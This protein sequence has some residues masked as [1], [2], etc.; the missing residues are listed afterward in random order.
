MRWPPA[1]T[2]AG[3]EKPISEIG[4]RRM[5][6]RTFMGVDLF[7]DNQA[8]TLRSLPQPGRTFRLLG[9]Y[10]QIVVVF[11]GDAWMP[12]WIERALEAA[13]AGSRPWLCQR[14]MQHALCELCGS[15]YRWPPGADVIGDD[16]RYLHCAILPVTPPCTN[17]DCPNWHAPPASPGG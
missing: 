14:C 9:R 15:P 5:V 7:H 4:G 2:C 10:R 17:L 11:W 12:N 16:G 3:C 13:E 6:A 8:V 1:A